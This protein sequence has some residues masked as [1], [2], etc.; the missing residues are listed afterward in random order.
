MFFR[1]QARIE[2]AKCQTGNPV[3][4]VYCFVVLGPN[5]EPMI[6]SKQMMFCIQIFGD[7]E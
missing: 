7:V 6:Y 1:G 2:E 5:D 4:R 3:I